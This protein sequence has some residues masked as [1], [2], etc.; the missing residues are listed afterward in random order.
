M[1]SRR[2]LG[3][4]I[5]SG[6]STRRFRAPPGRASRRQGARARRAVAGAHKMGPRTAVR[7]GARP[8]LQRHHDRRG[9]A[10]DPVLDDVR[11]R[12]GDRPAQRQLPA[13]GG[14]RRPRR[15]PAR[16]SVPIR[17][18]RQGPRLSRAEGGVLPRGLRARPGRR[19]TSSVLDAR[20]P[21]AVVRTPPEV[22]LYHRF[23]NDL[24]AQVLER[25][26]GAQTVVLPR[27]PEQ[28]AE[29]AAGGRLH[30]PRARD[31]R[32]VADRVRGPGRVRGRDHEPRG[33][34]ARNPRVHGVRGAS[35]GRR[36][37][38]DRRGQAA[39]ADQRRRARGRPSATPPATA[40]IGYDEIPGCSPTYCS[41]A[42][43][44]SLATLVSPGSRAQPS[45]AGSCYRRE[46]PEEVALCL[47]STS[48]S[49][50]LRLPPPLPPAR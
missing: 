49:V 22:S 25:L 46:P 10:A 45:P 24:F 21:I 1:I 2:R 31:R 17:G 34:G 39:A 32:P 7:P 30:R 20:Q 5:G 28:R 3:C 36:R 38:P 14:G 44:P 12:V 35:G 47:A 19:S 18:A 23:E 27:T 50:C 42:S 41:G 43:A 6:S 37:A 33:G 9:A 40:R 26:A 48:S 4:S 29:L 15:D 16:A 11:L 13:R 8:R